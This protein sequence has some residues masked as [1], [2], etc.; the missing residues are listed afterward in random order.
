MPLEERSLKIQAELDIELIYISEIESGYEVFIQ[1]TNG[2][3][4][5]S[6][7]TFL[8]APSSNISKS[9]AMQFC[10]AYATKVRDGGYDAMSYGDWYE[11]CPAPDSEIS[12]TLI[13]NESSLILPQ[14]APIYHGLPF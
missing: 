13:C 1:L 9:D 12:R 5:T 8:E 11:Q 2:A 4:Y 7:K 10:I 3:R 6:V 14:E